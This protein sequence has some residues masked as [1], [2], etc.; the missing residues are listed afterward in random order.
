[1][2]IN[3]LMYADDLVVFSPSSIGLRELLCV[4][5]TYALNHEMKLNHK[6]SAILISRGKYTKNVCHLHLS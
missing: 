2:N 6:K 3:N 5:G 1:M 4:C